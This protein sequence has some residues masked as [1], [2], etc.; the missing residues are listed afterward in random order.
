[1][2]VAQTSRHFHIVIFFFFSVCVLSDIF[3]KSLGVFNKKFLK[4][5][6]F[7]LFIQQIK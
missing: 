7:A 6:Y 2:T 4:L 1:M 3:D 5:I